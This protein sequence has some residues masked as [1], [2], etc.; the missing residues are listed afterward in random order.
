[1]RSVN[2]SES[3]VITSTNLA[4]IE[5]LE[6]ISAVAS[7]GFVSKVDALNKERKAIKHFV[8]GAGVPLLVLFV[9]GGLSYTAR[10]VSVSPVISCPDLE[11]IAFIE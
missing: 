5:E 8:L 3:Y 7:V 2:I 4:G 10:E 11:A 6:L 9:I 1:M